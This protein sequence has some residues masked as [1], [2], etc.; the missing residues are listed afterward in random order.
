MN[1]KIKN[2]LFYVWTPTNEVDLI[3]ITVMDCDNSIYF[4]F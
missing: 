4:S 2:Y 3:T 1:L